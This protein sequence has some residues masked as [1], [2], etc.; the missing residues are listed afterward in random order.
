M[1][2]KETEVQKDDRLK[3]EETFTTEQI[4]DKL[5]KTQRQSIGENRLPL[6]RVLNCKWQVDDG[7]PVCPHPIFGAGTLSGLDLCRSCAYY[8]GPCELICAAGLFYQK[9]LFHQ[10]HPLFPT[11]FLPQIPE[12][13]GAAIVLFFTCLVDFIVVVIVV[14]VLC[15]LGRN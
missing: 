6:S 10:S 8:Y 3:G 4:L 2:H 15:F 1:Y 5:I 13:G 11:V 12:P 14:V 9:K 7:V